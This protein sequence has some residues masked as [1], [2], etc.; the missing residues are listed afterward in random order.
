[1]TTDLTLLP[2]LTLETASSCPSEHLEPGP[3][4]AGLEAISIEQFAKSVAD[5]WFTDMMAATGRTH[6]Q[7]TNFMIRAAM[8]YTRIVHEF[9]QMS[10]VDRKV[11][12]GEH[13]ELV[14]AILDDV[15]ED[16][17][18]EELPPREY[19]PI[20]AP[21]VPNLSPQIAHMTNCEATNE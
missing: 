18:T 15:E 13:P 20:F 12:L 10:E 4:D 6:E 8:A 2:S 17:A 5:G 19:Q 3:F 11:L 7:V 9:E 1:M 21:C 14:G 16:L